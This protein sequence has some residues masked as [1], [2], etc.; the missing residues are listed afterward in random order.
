MA[1]TQ[2]DINLWAAA[3]PNATNAEIASAINA[4]GGIDALA[5]LNLAPVFSSPSTSAT[6]F[7][8]D[9]GSGFSNTINLGNG[10]YIT[11]TYS[12]TGDLTKIESSGWKDGANLIWG[13]SGNYDPRIPSSAGGLIGGFENVLGKT[14]EAASPL[15]ELVANT[16]GKL[17]PEQTA[18]LIMGGAALSGA[19]S[20]GTEA[21]SGLDLGGVGASPNTWLGDGVYAAGVPS[22]GAVWYDAGTSDLATSYGGPVVAPSAAAIAA[23]AAATPLTASQII[24]A[25]PLIPVANQILGDPLGINKTQ[26]T[27]QT[28][29]TGFAQVPIPAN[30][31]PPTY[32]QSNFQPID[33]NSIFTDQ[34]LLTGTQWQG[35]PNQRNMTFN[36]IFAAGQQ[37]TPMG[38]PVNINNLVSAILGQT[39]TSQ[40]PA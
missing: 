32:S 19:D 35:L 5:G 17:T 20:V 1:L 13:E 37:S 24:K 21:V 10:Q 3:N 39:A 15:N 7:N 38:S 4:V 29:T 26:Q 2:Q 22:S 40:K 11:P 36:D 6:S 14:T 28:G 34:N 12:D 30:W 31:K 16:A 33:L 9:G 18:F 23:T 8:F 25:L 27:G